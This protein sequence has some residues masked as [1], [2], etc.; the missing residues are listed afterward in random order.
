MRSQILV[1]VVAFGLGVVA[2]LLYKGERGSRASGEARAPAPPVD[3]LAREARLREVEARNKELT[4]ELESLRRDP[5]AARD[6]DAPGEGEP[7]AVE[8]P[9][10]G[11][12]FVRPATEASLGVVDW[13]ITG[14]AMANL[15]P[16]L[17]EAAEVSNGKRELRPALWG[18]V[19]NSL[20]PV[21]TEAIK[22]DQ[23]GGQW[24]SPSFL[25]N[26]VHATLREAGQPLDA[27]QEEALGAIGSR[28]YD[29]DARRRAGYG[30]TT[31]RMRQMVDEARMLD[32]FFAE[33]EPILA[34]AQRAVL[35]PPGVRGIVDLDVFGTSSV[36]DEKLK[37]LKYADRAGLRAAAAAAHM[38]ELGLRPEMLSAVEGV[39]A[40]WEHALPDGFVLHQASAAAAKDVKM[41]TSDR[42]L[43]A[44]DRQ[45]ALYEA[46]LARVPLL[47][48]EK[49]RILEREE[50]LVPLLVPNTSRSTIPRTPGG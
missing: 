39:L 27:K 21:M 24:S 31:P 9:Q 44:A 41:E 25:A 5:Q 34:D 19:L 45:L 14:A 16:L 18:E 38:K 43:A 49:Q 12:R 42:V 13:H 11:P 15:M 48:E 33:V 1:A 6:A 8:A 2:T 32:R 20:G 10:R 4:A 35:Y 30:E 17:S 46:L 50:V 36:W 7:Q 3:S 26:L 23:A 29:D 22:H 37:R 47:D 40:D 28:H